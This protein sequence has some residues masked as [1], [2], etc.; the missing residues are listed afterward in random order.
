MARIKGN[1]FKTRIEYLYEKVEENKRME[2]LSM[3]SDECRKSIQNVLVTNWYPFSH[4]VELINA[5][6]K[7]LSMENPNIIEEL[8]RYSAIKSSK[9]IYKI[10]FII[11]KPKTILEK[12]PAMW[13][14]MMEGGKVMLD[15]KGDRD[16][17][18]SLIEFNEELPELFARSLIG[19]T[20]GLLELAGAKNIQMT[21]I[22]MPSKTD[23]TLVVNA[24]WD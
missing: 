7:V 24:K 14:T 18:L 4:I 8:G 10:F 2:I 23:N 3:L 11:L 1:L 12:I 20:K 13:V 22:K 16:V 5:M 17:I 15:F 9:G 6:H 21:A 19:W